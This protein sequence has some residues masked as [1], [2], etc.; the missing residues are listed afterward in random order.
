MRMLSMEKSPEVQQLKGLGLPAFSDILISLGTR[1]EESVDPILRSVATR[2]QSWDSELSPVW[3]KPVYGLFL[4]LLSLLIY[5]PSWIFDPI[6]KEKSSPAVMIAPL[7]KMDPMIAPD[8]LLIYL[9][10]KPICYEE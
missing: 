1:I 10:P 6:P 3:R 5:L 4:L 9:S 7:P 2:L 8:T